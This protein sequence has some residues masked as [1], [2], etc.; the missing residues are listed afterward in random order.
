MNEKLANT[1]GED[2]AENYQKKVQQKRQSRN[3]LSA[4][5]KAIVADKAVNQ[6]ALDDGEPMF[7]YTDTNG[8]VHRVMLMEFPDLENGTVYSYANEL[9]TGAVSIPFD[10]LGEWISCLFNEGKE[11]VAEF[12]EGDPYLM[13][14]Q[15][16]TWENDSGEENEQLS[17]VTAAMTLEEVNELA[18]R[19]LEEEGFSGADEDDIEEETVDQVIDDSPDEDEE[20]SSD[21]EEPAIGED[22]D[23]EE[24]EDDGGFLDDDDEDEEEEETEDFEYEGFDPDEIKEKVESLAGKDERVWDA[25]RDSAWSEKIAN[26][27]VNGTDYEDAEKVEELAMTYIV[28]GEDALY[29]LFDDGEEEADDEEDEDDE[30]ELLFG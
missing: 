6:G 17:P 9:S 2:F 15:H 19:S 25:E 20:D 1:F 11:A 27:I 7:D 29:D 26:V 18:N 4:E 24:E 28:D 3:Q 10:Y 8:V 12:E 21:D 30:D 13:V 5:D 22:D 14:G 16:G 23:D